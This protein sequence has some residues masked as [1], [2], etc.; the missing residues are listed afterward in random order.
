[1]PKMDDQKLHIY[2]KLSE[3]TWNYLK[4]NKSNTF[5]VISLQALVMLEVKNH[6]E[7]DYRWYKDFIIKGSFFSQNWVIK[8]ISDLTATCLQPVY[9]MKRQRNWFN[10]NFI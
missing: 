8:F 10:F 6:N 9:K 4:L 2:L 3:I 5:V 7:I 1:M